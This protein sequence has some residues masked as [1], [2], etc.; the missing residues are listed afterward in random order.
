M[1]RFGP[2]TAVKSLQLWGLHPHAAVV[3]GASRIVSDD[4]SEA[5]LEGFYEGL[6]DPEAR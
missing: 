1:P 4:P 3:I 6:S 5:R 2:P